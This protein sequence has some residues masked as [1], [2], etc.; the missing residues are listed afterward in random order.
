M[1][2]LSSSQIFVGSGGSGRSYRSEIVVTNAS[3]LAGVLDSTK[4]YLLDGEIDMG[5]TQI[6]VPEGG[7]TID[8]FGFNI[9][10]L[11]STEDNYSLFI[12]PG[13]GYSGDLV[14]Y[15]IDMSTSGTNSK[16]FD[17]DNAGNF[18]AIDI[19]SCNFTNCTSCGE[20]TAYRQFFMTGSALLRCVDGIT[21]SGTMVGGITIE[22][23]IVILAGVTFTGAVLKAGTALLINNSCRSNFNGLALTAP[24]VFCDFAPSNINLDAGFIMNGTRMPANL[25]AFPNM[26]STSVKA[27]FSNSQGTPNTYPGAVMTIGASGTIVISVV[28]TFYP[29]TGTGVLSDLTWFQA[30]GTTA[31]EYISDQEIELIIDGNLNFSG[32]TNDTMSIQVW[33]Y[34]AA[35]TTW[36]A[37]SPSFTATLNGGQAQDRAESVPVGAY[38]SVVS[39]DRLELRIANTKGTGNIDI[40]TGGQLRISER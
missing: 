12:S 20:V 21:F 16:V 35:T 34:T 25:N 14:L 6:I 7:L 28:D 4:V 38:T 15:N 32:A 39:G 11:I 24:G 10:R 37:I 26:P 3:E 33:K 31:V 1:P 13:G 30:S 8:G 23:S 17:I 18:N 40:I 5:T 2:G 9:S 27:R 36:A 22:S 19:V 29:L